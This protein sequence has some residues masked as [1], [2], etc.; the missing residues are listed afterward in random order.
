V[1]MFNP[2]YTMMMEMPGIFLLHSKEVPQ[3][4][5]QQLQS[6]PS[7]PFYLSS[8]SLFLNRRQVKKN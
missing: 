5:I 3:R 7:V 1:I 6:T 4:L 8:I 2:S